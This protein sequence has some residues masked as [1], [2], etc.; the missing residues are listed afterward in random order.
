MDQSGG[1][2]TTRSLG[3]APLG[4]NLVDAAERGALR[5]IWVA[6]AEAALDLATPGEFMD[7]LHEFVRPVLRYETVVCGTG[8]FAPHTVMTDRLLVR[9]FPKAILEALRDSGGVIALPRGAK[10]RD[11]I[12]RTLD[13]TRVEDGLRSKR[14]PGAPSVLGRLAVFDRAGA[15]CRFGSYFLFGRLRESPSARQHYLAAILGPIMHDALT[16]ALDGEP[17]LRPALAAGVRLTRRETELLNWL[18]AGQTTGQI[19]LASHR[20]AHTVANQIRAILRKL[21]ARNRTEAIALALGLGLVQPQERPART[22]LVAAQVLAIYEIAPDCARVLPAGPSHAVAE[23]ADVVVVDD[24]H[25][26][27]ISVD[28]G[29]TD[30]LETELAHVF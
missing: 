26:L 4:R 11:R 13:L 9:G 12:L 30:E 3:A 28:D 5:E 6:A 10:Q 18:V 23:A 19:A 22:R 2:G 21:E 1:S 8:M 24:T 14:G 15:S 25:R 17:S 20:S 29:W 7:W 27:K 16:R